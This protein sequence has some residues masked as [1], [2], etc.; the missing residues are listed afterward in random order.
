[1]A[2]SDPAFVTQSNSAPARPPHILL[3][4]DADDLRSVV[5][6]RLRQ[7]GYSVTECSDG[8]E[9]LARLRSYLRPDATETPS[10]TGKYDLVIS[11]VRMPGVL[12]TSVVE[13]A[14][15]CPDFPP[16]ILITGFGDDETHQ[17]A[18][19][20]GVAAVMDKPF[21]MSDL[22]EKVRTA[23]AARD[24]NHSGQARPY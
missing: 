13:G 5:A 19:R 7:Q 4:E 9:L 10:E 11:D 18:R 23:I 15:D 3:A 2:I 12:G 20:M 24:P 17:Q 1:M 16:T 8:A 14:A 21:D 22:L 6:L